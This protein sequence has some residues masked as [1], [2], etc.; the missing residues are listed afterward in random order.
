[1][2]VYPGGPP[3]YVKRTEKDGPT[4]LLALLHM[5]SYEIKNGSLHWTMRT[6]DGVEFSGGIGLTRVPGTYI[7]VT[8]KVPVTLHKRY[9]GLAM[10]FIFVVDRRDTVNLW[11]TR[12]GRE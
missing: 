4:I 1:L 11:K 6:A 5:V 12:G 10:D 7:K 2:A 9:S 8:P 3:V